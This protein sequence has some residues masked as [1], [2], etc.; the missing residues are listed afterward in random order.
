[1]K[2]PSS[3]STD[4]K[5]DPNP[6]EAKQEANQHERERGEQT[7]E[8]IRYREAISEHGFGGETLGNSGEANQ[9]AGVGFGIGEEAGDTDGGELRST[10]RE[11]GYSGGSAVG[12]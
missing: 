1:M 8:N 7:A 2:A 12:A 5:L 11:Q 9:A 4:N 3:S 10:R 6:N